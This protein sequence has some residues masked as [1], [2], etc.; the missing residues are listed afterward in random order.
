MNI[1]KLSAFKTDLIF[2]TCISKCHLKI[3]II[4]SVYAFL[5]NFSADTTREVV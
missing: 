5:K 3:K 1:L 4:Q 2:I